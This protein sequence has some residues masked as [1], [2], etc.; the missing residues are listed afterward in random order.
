VIRNI[1]DGIVTHSMF[2][3]RMHHV[4]AGV[5]GGSAGTPNKIILHG[6]PL[7][8]PI[9]WH[10]LNPGDVIEVHLPSGGG[11]YPASERS[12]E[13]ILNDLA[14]GLLSPEGAKAQYGF[15]R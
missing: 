15:T 5:L 3:S 9:G 6:Q 11:K 14:E 12:C 2:Y 1:G 8:N 4:A 7:T 13:A 10:D